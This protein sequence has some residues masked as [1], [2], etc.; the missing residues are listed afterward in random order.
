MSLSQEALET[1]WHSSAPGRLTPWQQAFALG[2][3]EASKEINGGHVN[4]TWIASKLRKSDETGQNYSD[5]A[6]GHSAVSE[7]LTKVKS[8]P[9]WFP[10]KH[11]GAKRGPKPLL[12]ASKRAR[13]A[14]SAMSQ[15]A[16]GSE[17]S[18]DVTVV[19]C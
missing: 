9:R 14:L 4:T 12:T 11:S 6:P 10:G 16:E 2:L 19:R 13:I 18:V 5:E 3:A 17:P 1:L 8:D 15:K 7:F